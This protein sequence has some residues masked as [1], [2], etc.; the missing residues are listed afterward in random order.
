MIVWGASTKLV[1]EDEELQKH[2]IELSQHGVKLESCKWCSEQFQV[3]D[4]M[5]TLGF[6]NKYMG[7]VLTEYLQKDEKVL[8]F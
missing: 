4:K 5:E 2:I 6:E 7:E 8:T 1:A 3:S